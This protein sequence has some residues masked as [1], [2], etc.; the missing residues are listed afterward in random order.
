M[1]KTCFRNMIQQYIALWAFNNIEK[2]DRMTIYFSRKNGI[3]CTRNKEL[4]RL[5]YYSLTKIVKR[6][7]FELDNILF[8]LNIIFRSV[9]G[10]YTK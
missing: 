7:L 4:F 1:D 5:V 6:K 3:T 8:S 9:Y 2:F 10:E